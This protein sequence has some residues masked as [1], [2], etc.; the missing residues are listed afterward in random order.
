[1]ASLGEEERILVE[2]SRRG[3]TAAFNQLVRAYERPLFNTAYRLC[4][5]HDDAADMAQEAFVRA[6]N[7]LKSFRGDLP[8]PCPL[9]IHDNP[10]PTCA[11]PKA[12][13]LGPHGRQAGFPH[14]LLHILPQP[15]AVLG[16]AAIRTETDE[17]VPLCVRDSSLRQPV[18]KFAHGWES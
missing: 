13:R 2:R 12:T 5:S 6:W 3:D 14:P 1:M 7:N 15:F 8:V 18:G 16:I 11:N 17:N 10:W 4:G 9:R